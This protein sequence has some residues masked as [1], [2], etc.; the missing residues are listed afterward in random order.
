MRSGPR[1]QS[2]LRRTRHSSFV[3]GIRWTVRPFEHS[4][5]RHSR[6]S[7]SLG[8]RYA[9]NRSDSAFGP[10]KWRQCTRTDPVRRVLSALS[11]GDPPGCAPARHILVLVITVDKWITSSLDDVLVFLASARALGRARD[12]GI[13][14]SPVIAD[15]T[16]TLRVQVVHAP[17]SPLA[18][19]GPIRDGD[20]R[21]IL[22]GHCGLDRGMFALD[23]VPQISKVCGSWAAVRRGGDPRAAWPPPSPQ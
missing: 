23:P 4:G 13:E 11:A 15:Q 22:G 21:A 2:S 3:L 12:N 17:R 8:A 18:H 20:D 16:D 6:S 10:R 5:T 1:L 19:P 7:E 14:L 9:G